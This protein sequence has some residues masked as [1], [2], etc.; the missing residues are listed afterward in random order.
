MPSE[1]LHSWS[2]TAA[3]NANA[4]TA[5]NW[6]EGMARAAV[7]DSSRS[8]MAAIAK[9]RNLLN[10]S[11]TTTG[12]ANA[13]NFLSG[14]G[15]T[16]LPTGL[17][18]MLKIGTDLSNT[19]PTTL[20]CDVT[21]A[22]A[23]KTVLGNDLT[24]SELIAGTFA[25]FIY[26]GTNWVLVQNIPGATLLARATLSG[27]AGSVAFTNIFTDAYDYYTFL[28]TNLRPAT[29]NASMI[30]QISDTNG[31]SWITTN[32]YKTHYV[33]IATGAID[34]G[35]YTVNSVVLPYNDGIVTNP[36]MNNT[37]TVATQ[38]SYS[39]VRVFR[40]QQ[41][42]LPDDPAQFLFD[43]INIYDVTGLVWYQGA[44]FVYNGFNAI[45]FVMKP[46]NVDTGNFAVYG[47]RK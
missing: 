47:M 3:D 34:S 38:P 37:A 42:V 41:A 5:I 12:L 9:N 44:G 8:V 6:Q 36:A 4:D 35:T 29:N 39:T 20:N 2:T 16:T 23:V 21:G 26:N 7:N 43:A 30:M 27:T 14:V 24:G 28:I 25:D 32:I 45:R 11:I 10:G 15:Y 46:G 13:Q 40:S 33:Y 22:V 17:K 1:D 31:A 18:V 19:G